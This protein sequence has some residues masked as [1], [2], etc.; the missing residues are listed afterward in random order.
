M[1][2]RDLPA[3][4]AVPVGGYVIATEPTA[5][6]AL[7]IFVKVPGS[8]IGGGGGP[9]DGSTWD[10]GASV[11]DAGASL[12]DGASPSTRWLDAFANWLASLPHTPPTQP[13]RPWNDS[14]RLAFTGVT[15]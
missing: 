5:D 6:P 8:N 14:G 9:S 13:G 1:R 7:S 11:W 4:G 10:A 2:I 12:W 3:R 15:S